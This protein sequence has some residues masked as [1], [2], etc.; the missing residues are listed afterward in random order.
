M[1]TAFAHAQ[2]ETTKKLQTP[3]LPQVWWQAH[4]RGKIEKIRGAIKQ[5]LHVNG[6]G[7][8]AKPGRNDDLSR[9]L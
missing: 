5:D 4:K 2:P 6:L 1:G 8:H 9:S 3:P 7:L